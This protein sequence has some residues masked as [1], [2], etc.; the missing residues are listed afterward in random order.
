VT[1]KNQNQEMPDYVPVERLKNFSPET[2]DE[3]KGEPT[4]STH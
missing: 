1:L 3:G 4:E 2:T